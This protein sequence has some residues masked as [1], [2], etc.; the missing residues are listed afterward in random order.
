MARK[1]RKLRK[2]HLRL[3]THRRWLR[4]RLLTHRRWLHLRQR[5]RTG[6]LQWRWRGRQPP[7]ATTLPCRPCPPPP[8]LPLLLQRQTLRPQQQRRRRRGRRRRR[9]RGV[10]ARHGAW[11]LARHVRQPAC[12]RS[13]RN[14]SD[15]HSSAHMYLALCYW[16]VLCML[17]CMLYCAVSPYALTSCRVVSCRAG[18]LRSWRDSQYAWTTSKRRCQRQ[19]PHVYID[20]CSLRAACVHVARSS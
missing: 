17:C 15:A 11:S 3:L 18:P 1:L 13:R 14:A 20:C 9:R 16:V 2:L 4:L 12:A 5:R 10:R 7:W 19:A 8:S 6:R